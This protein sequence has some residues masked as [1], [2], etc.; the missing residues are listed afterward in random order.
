L[1]VDGNVSEKYTVFSFK[2]ERGDIC[3]FG[4][5]AYIFRAEDGDSRF[6]QNA[7]ICVRVYKASKPIIKSFSNISSLVL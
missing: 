3:F 4:K 6:L 7:G 5:R 2:D 1:K